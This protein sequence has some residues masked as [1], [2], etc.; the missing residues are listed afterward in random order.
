[1]MSDQPQFGKKP[2]YAADGEL[3]EVGAGATA[4]STLRHQFSDEYEGFDSQHTGATHAAEEAESTEDEIPPPVDGFWGEDSIEGLKEPEIKTYIPPSQLQQAA[5]AAEEMWGGAASAPQPYNPPSA[6]PHYEAE[7]EVE[8]IEQPQEQ[9]YQ[10]QQPEA[11]GEQE[12]RFT[13]YEAPQPIQEEVLEEEAPVIIS[14]EIEQSW[15][16]EPVAEATEEIQYEAAEEN[17][18]SGPKLSMPE[19]EYVEENFVAPVE[20][21]AET[22]MPTAVAPMP[23]SNEPLTVQ[24]ELLQ[25]VRQHQEWL[26]TSGRE[27]RRAT[28]R[29]DYFRGA[30]FSGLM[31][32]EASFRGA[33]LPATKFRGANLD[34]ADFVE[35]DLSAADFTHAT[36]NGATFQRAL[37]SQTDFSL[38]TAQEADF[39]AIDAIGA[40]FQRAVMEWAIFRD[41]QLGGSDFRQAN[42]SKANLRNASFFRAKMEDANLTQADCRETN[43]DGAVMDRAMLLQANFR[44]ANLQGV[45]MQAADFSQALD[46]PMDAQADAA[47]K[48]REHLQQ[49]AQRMEQIKAELE[50]KERELEIEREKLRGSPAASR[51]PLDDLSEPLIPRERLN[52]YAEGMEMTAILKSHSKLFM[53]IGAAWLLIVLGVVGVVLSALSEMESSEVNFLELV[54]LGFL[55]FVPLVLAVIGVIKSMQLSSRLL[56]Y[57]RER[58]S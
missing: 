24:D 6:P 46:V 25:I 43:F 3:E 14:S 45:A 32:A 49:E 56:E 33:T 23:V 12:H 29:D 37:L 21:V 4:D 30:D 54:I 27:G 17:Y 7:P 53:R 47:Q 35:A 34:R 55:L 22:E 48:E 41:A 50:A 42:L 36:L 52:S 51:M 57:N 31:L 44:A 13:A 20:E 58:D 19:P 5:P 40:I 16:M 26:D 9:E 18:S 39:S 8:A 1:M 28:F 15:H 10:W 38:T 2:A 11:V